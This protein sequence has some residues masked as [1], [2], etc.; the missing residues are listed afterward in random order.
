MAQFDHPDPMP[1]LVRRLTCEAI[2]HSIDPMESSRKG[3]QCG[4][5]F[6]V[7]WDVA[8]RDDLWFWLIHYGLKARWRGLFSWRK[9]DRDDPMPF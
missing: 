8:P 5:C 9:R 7:S 3:C 2:G 4:R 6:R 1:S